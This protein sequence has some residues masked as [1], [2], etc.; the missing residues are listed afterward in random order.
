[1]RNDK[2]PER[3]T[4]RMG[5]W[6]V[7]RESRERRIVAL[8]L[9]AVA[10]A[11]LGIPT[12][13]AVQFN[14]TFQ[15]SCAGN[16]TGLLRAENY[17]AEFNNAHV[18]LMNYS[19]AAYSYTLCCETDGTHT[20]DNACSNENSTTV[21]RAYNTSGNHVQTPQ[22]NPTT[23]DERVCMALSPG[24]LTCEYVN[25]S[26]SAGFNPLFSMASSGTSN[27]TNAHIG[28]YSWY[29]LSVCCQGGNA[30]PNVPTLSYP[31]NDNTSVFERNISFDWSD[32]T[33]PDSDA[34]TYDLNITSN[35]P[36]CIVTEEW[37]D[38]AVSTQTSS[39]LSVDCVYNWTARACDPTQCSDYA[40]VWNFTIAS[41][42]GINFTVN[43][44]EFGSMNNTDKNDTS[45]GKPPP[46]TVENTGNVDANVTLK[47]ND[48]LF[49]SVALG[50]LYFQYKARLNE[51]GAYNPVESQESYA[52]VT[53]A[54]TTLFGDLNYEGDRDSA[55][56]DINITVPNDEVAGYKSSIVQVYGSYTP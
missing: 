51:A 23:Y 43:A 15:T 29:T 45:D 42:I 14:C 8:L 12:V 5:W 25:G 40:P 32:S 36:D 30:P 1:M 2:K 19:G 22:G 16:E 6:A 41:V 50:T 20:M 44:T 17:S 53:A 47:A 11:L 28:N 13:S 48:G 35:D 56:V 39:E 9:C 21:L 4:H 33:D 46:F 3:A 52:N 18:Q 49:T 27:E 38:L 10:C 54:Y 31:L 37:K 55:Y 26:C 24:N 7:G 34:V